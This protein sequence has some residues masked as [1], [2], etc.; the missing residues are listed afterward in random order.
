MREEDM[1][2]GWAVMHA[3]AELLGISPFDAFCSH[4]MAD[5]GGCFWRICREA[6]GRTAMALVNGPGEH[7]VTPAE[8]IERL[9]RGS[10]AEVAA[11]LTSR[12]VDV[13]ADPI[14][15]SAFRASGD[16]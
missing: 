14:I 4:D 16:A 1:P 3:A 10:I 6:G 9:F 7:P 15:S 2:A 12:G 5:G 8:A 13:E 11:Y